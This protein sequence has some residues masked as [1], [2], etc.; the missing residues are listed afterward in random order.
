MLSIITACSRPQNLKE[1][2]KSIDF[3]LVTK[4]YIVYDTS[5]DRTYTPEFATEEKI[6]ELNC[7]KEGYAGHPQINMALDLIKEGYVYIMDDDNIFHKNFW[8]LLPTLDSEFVYTWDQDRIQEGR[9]LKGGQIEETKIDTSQFIVPRNL[10]GSIRWAEKKSAGD[11]RF[12]SQIYKKYG[13]KF[14]YIPQVACYHN[15]IPKVK[16]AI[17]FFGLTRSLKLTLDSIEKY[18]FDPL[19][20]HGI[21]YDI[22]LHTYKMKTAYS[23]PRAGEKDLIL[24]ADEYK[25]LEPTYHM[26]ESKEA[27]SKKLDLEKYRTHG[28]PW[29]KET[30]ARPGDFSTLDNH[31]L[32]LWSLK[33]LTKLWSEAKSR[34]SHIIYCR[35]DVLYQVP[36]DISW[37]SFSPKSKKIYIPNFGLCGNVNDRFALGRPEEMRLYGNRFDDALAYSKKKPLASEAYL[38]DTMR[39]HRIKYEHVNFYFIRVRA[40]GKK[41]GIDVSQIKTLTRRLRADKKKNITRKIKIGLY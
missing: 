17:C 5:R 8:R 41:N 37:F 38:I 22:F 39:R 6:K 13:D 40:N 21:R 36:L 9:I 11:F 18:I 14:K 15:F 29:G 7:N 34:Y 10:I 31:I 24:D 35:P 19:R 27:V 12:I 32:Y 2:Y 20:L 33:Q 26:V 25:L 4:W 28:N 16:V 30:S 3:S 23:N 1:I